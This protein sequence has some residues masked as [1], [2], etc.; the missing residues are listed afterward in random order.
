MWVVSPTVQGANGHPYDSEGGGIEDADYEH[1]KS[2]HLPP[3]MY[4]QGLYRNQVVAAGI[5]VITTILAQVLGGD[6]APISSTRTAQNPRK[7]KAL[8]E[9]ADF[10]P[11][12]LEEEA[13]GDGPWALGHLF[14]HAH[15]KLSSH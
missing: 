8:V 7:H 12:Y 15:S 4:C 2:M 10:I 13:L 5:Y 6:V 1:F 3:W 14:V 9:V 11:H